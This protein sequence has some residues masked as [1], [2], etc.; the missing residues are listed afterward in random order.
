MILQ[1]ISIL[2]TVL[3]LP[4]FKPN[5]GEANLNQVSE[6]TS[7]YSLNIDSL[8]TQIKNSGWNNTILASYHFV[9][10]NSGKE[11][12]A[13]LKSL[14]HGYE[15]SFL[16]ALILKKEQKYEAMFDTLF[17]SL[18]E[19]INYLPY[20]EE[21]VFSASANNKLNL[22]EEKIKKEDFQNKE[23]LSGLINLSRGLNSQA[24]NLLN[25]ALNNKL[26]KN[27]FFQLSYAYRN[28][29]NYENGNKTLN[30]AEELFSDDKWFI[31]KVRLA[32]GSLF[33]LSGDYD[34][35]QKYYNNSLKLA[36]ENS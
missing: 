22:I 13:N 33:F 6:N 2:I 29:G 7:R 9:I 4:L 23:F 12:D 28:N 35:A 3:L 14:P 15:V 18:T 21:L 32:Q 24:I 34:Q 36:L 17:T 1:K 5:N 19:E 20:Y 10:T 11:I 8:N 16:R 25:D 31:T 27:I 26:D 30:R